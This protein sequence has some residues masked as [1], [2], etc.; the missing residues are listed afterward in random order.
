MIQFFKSGRSQAGISNWFRGTLSSAFPVAILDVHILELAGLENFTA[1][2]ALDEFALFAAGDDLHPR[3]RTGAIY[4]LL[5]VG[6]A[7]ARRW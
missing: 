4:S 2:Q 7:G 1:F 6:C 5:L 3:V